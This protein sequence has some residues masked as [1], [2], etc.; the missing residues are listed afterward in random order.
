MIIEKLQKEDIPELL[1]LYK[2]LVSFENT[3]EKSQD[4]YEEILKDENYSVFVV[5]ENNQ[6]IGS[7]MAICCKSLACEGKNFLVIEDVIVKEGLR[8]RGVGRKLFEYIDEYAIKNNCMYSI[9]VSSD[10]RKG[11]HAFYEKMGF[12]DGVRG[13]RKLYE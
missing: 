12:A 3:L 6:L 5:K 8:G 2:M 4:I 9:L 11:A 7:A 1:E 13:F 10:Y